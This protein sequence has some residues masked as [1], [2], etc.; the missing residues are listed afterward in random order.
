M[1]VLDEKVALR[2]TAWV[3]NI[4]VFAMCV[5][6]SC[7]YRNIMQDSFTFTVEELAFVVEKC[8]ALDTAGVSTAEPQTTQIDEHS[9]DSSGEVDERDAIPSKEDLD[10][11]GLKLIAGWVNQITKSVVLSI[12]KLSIRVECHSSALLVSLEDIHFKDLSKVEDVQLTEDVE[13]PVI[14]TADDG[15]SL[16]H[17]N[18]SFEGDSDD[19]VA[20]DMD[21]VISF[22]GP[23]ATLIPDIQN[24]E[25]T[26]PVLT[27]AEQSFF[28]LRAQVSRSD[29]SVTIIAYL[30]T[31]AR[32]KLTLSSRSVHDVLNCFR[33]NG[34]S[35]GSEMDDNSDS[36]YESYSGED[37]SETD[38]D[39]THA[40]QSID[41]SPVASSS[42]TTN[43][44][45]ETG[46]PCHGGGQSGL[47]MYQ[48]F[49]ESQAADDVAIVPSGELA[50][51]SM[52]MRC[53]GI[54]VVFTSSSTANRWAHGHEIGF[55]VHDIRLTRGKVG[56]DHVDTP[57]EGQSIL[58]VAELFVSLC[59]EHDSSKPELLLSCTS[60]DDC[61]GV[62][63]TSVPTLDEV[64]VAPVS[65]FLRPD[66]ISRLQD[67]A[68]EALTLVSAFTN[69]TKDGSEG[70]SSSN[71]LEQPNKCLRVSVAELCAVACHQWDAVQS[72]DESSNLN[73]EGSGAVAI[74]AF[75]TELHFEQDELGVK[76]S[77]K[78]V[79]V[80]CLPCTDIADVLNS[81]SKASSVAPLLCVCPIDA[82]QDGTSEPIAIRACFRNG[83]N[84][85]RLPRL[86]TDDGDFNK[87][88]NSQ[89][90]FVSEGSVSFNQM[91]DKFCD[92]GKM[93]SIKYEEPC[94]TVQQVLVGSCT[95][96]LPA[97]KISESIHALALTFAEIA[98]DDSR[99]SSVTTRPLHSDTQASSRQLHLHV[100]KLHMELPTTSPQL[101][102]FILKADTLSAFVGPAGSCVS[103]NAVYLTAHRRSQ[104][105]AEMVPNTVLSVVGVGDKP[106]VEVIALGGTEVRGHMQRT[107]TTFV[108]SQNIRVFG[109]NGFAWMAQF[110]T[111]LDAYTQ[112]LVPATCNAP[113]EFRENAWQSDPIQLH[114]HLINSAV[115]VP[116]RNSVAE[117]EPD[118]V[119]VNCGKLYFSMTSG[120]SF[121]DTKENENFFTRECASSNVIECHVEDAC[122]TFMSPDIEAYRL[123]SLNQTTLN[124]RSRKTAASTY[125]DLFHYRSLQR[126][127]QRQSTAL[128]G[129]TMCVTVIP[130]VLPRV[131]NILD[132]LQS[133]HPSDVGILST[134]ET[135]SSTTSGSTGPGKS[136]DSQMPVD[137][138]SLSNL[139]RRAG[140]EVD[141]FDGVDF[142]AYATPATLRTLRAAR[143]LHDKDID[144]EWEL[145]PSIVDSSFESA[146][147]VP[148]EV[149]PVGND[150]DFSTISPTA[151]NIDVHELHSASTI[152]S[153]RWYPHEFT[154]VKD[155]FGSSTS[156]FDDSKSGAHQPSD[157]IGQDSTSLRSPQNVFAPDDTFF[158]FI[159]PGS[160]H[161]AWAETHPVSISEEGSPAPHRH[162]KSPSPRPALME[163]VLEDAPG[164][165][166]RF[167]VHAVALKVEIVDVTDT[168]GVKMGQHVDHPPPYVVQ[169]PQDS[170]HQDSLQD[171]II[172][173]YI[174]RVLNAR[175]G[176][177]LREDGRSALAKPADAF[178]F[179]ADIGH[180]YDRIVVSLDDIACRVDSFP[181]SEAGPGRISQQCGFR[182]GHIVAH[183]L[184]RS[185]GS[186]RSLRDTSCV[187]LEV[188][189]ALL[190][191]DRCAF[192]GA[193]IGC[194][195]QDE[196]VR[197][198]E[199]PSLTSAY[200]S[201]SSTSVSAGNPFE[202]N[203]NRPDVGAAGPAL[204][205][206]AA[207]S[208]DSVRLSLRVATV[209]FLRRLV[210]ALTPSSDESA[211]TANDRAARDNSGT[212]SMF[213]KSIHSGQFDIVADF[214]AKQKFNEPILHRL[215]RMLSPMPRSSRKVPGSGF[216]TGHT[217]GGFD[218]SGS[219]ADDS[220]PESGPLESD[221]E[222]PNM[223][224]WIPTIRGLKLAVPECDLESCYGVHE[225][226][227]LWLENWAQH[228][229]NN[230]LLKVSASLAIGLAG[231]SGADSI[232]GL[233]SKV[234]QVRSKL[235]RLFPLDALS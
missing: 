124:V 11:E 108:T 155:H 61:P 123:L 140:K 19:D 113:T 12:L 230:D 126:A 184:I 62:L 56:N 158:A 218:R 146:V 22:H 82:E 110:Q 88:Q 157:A 207:L 131:I 33:A 21:K 216:A 153:A 186:A 105:G 101:P 169:A 170:L 133:P 31:L 60:E 200:Y 53:V 18:E 234:K 202:G 221:A 119:V 174:D 125:R 197:S 27:T 66:T 63:F 143:A 209:E 86:W 98:R 36:Q 92:A 212:D 160:P 55:H 68:D 29:D 195:S 76:L 78:L 35:F 196:L 134:S 20:V 44:G 45:D 121:S 25:E 116:S 15:R 3:Q 187:L 154:T 141:L 161:G 149:L 103:L 173:D 85:P 52:V 59:H 38:S 201:E 192:K 185:E 54:E 151:S 190:E 28:Q 152:P 57:V 1:S 50:P 83:V 77:T 171:A 235:A 189:G 206:D 233:H 130:Q 193:C 4:N 178:E 87:I 120:D 84:G 37:E 188:G 167:Q 208:M 67:L 122:A 180:P 80:T 79:S 104:T 49:I 219:S 204:D 215:S 175:V 30:V 168:G 214:V 191:S 224:Y 203:H 129:G 162:R 205:W 34:V 112:L 183:D 95:I 47:K 51:G 177:Q 159:L 225:A 71:A 229:L 127:T 48:K 198:Q 58:S 17:E 89:P 137:V 163:G 96:C 150:H 220:G 226:A 145:V 43:T 232:D 227:H 46:Q 156:T 181:L 8:G 73:E 210:S 102:H 72:A 32:L 14:S 7:S 179:S 93:M 147:P 217:V 6:L 182:I 166:S 228:L 164:W 213:F 64:K 139:D 144:D 24:P 135:A 26:L 13:A 231:Y 91:R 97:P 23:L 99:D 9:T 65:T 142:E 176:D 42:K 136:D 132:S 41:G 128:H 199:A 69:P 165:T 81:E 109:S 114:V 94:A 39:D 172:D 138:V 90:R 111:S 117:V 118:S 70:S 2:R 106:C 40:A 223:L 10:N 5:T 115:H 222:L 107:Y 148:A 75:G 211:P 74:L 194:H 16:D 100:L